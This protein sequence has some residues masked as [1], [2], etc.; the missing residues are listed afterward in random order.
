MRLFLKHYI[1]RK[2]CSSTSAYKKK[3]HLSVSISV[4]VSVS[5]SVLYLYMCMHIVNKKSVP[6]RVPSLACREERNFIQVEWLKQNSSS[7]AV[8]GKHLSSSNETAQ[9]LTLQ[10]G[11]ADPVRQPHQG[12]LRFGWK[13]KVC[14]SQ[15]SSLNKEKFPPMA[16]DWQ[17]RTWNKHILIVQKSTILI[18]CYW[19]SLIGHFKK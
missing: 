3:F 8:Q 13:L 12:K 6:P 17:I 19:D 18:G 15:R 1:L 10:L 7:D 11:K 16:P 4:S 2:H 9:Q 14:S 5:V